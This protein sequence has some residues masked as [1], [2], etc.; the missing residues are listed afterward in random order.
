MEFICDP[1]L[2][3]DV[4]HGTPIGLRPA[5]SIATNAYGSIGVFLKPFTG[6]CLK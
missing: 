3:A 2:P 4:S 5:D 6:K 1:R